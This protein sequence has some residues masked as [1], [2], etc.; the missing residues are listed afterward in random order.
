MSLGGLDEQ[1]LSSPLLLAVVINNKTSFS[2]DPFFFFRPA[3]SGNLHMP[4]TLEV[5]SLNHWAAREV[6]RRSF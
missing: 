5:R 1:E 2:K 3:A 4:P 6:P